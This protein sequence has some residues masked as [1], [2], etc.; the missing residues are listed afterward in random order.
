MSKKPRSAEDE[1]EMF[2]DGS[3]REIRALLREL[4]KS[5]ASGDNSHGSVLA[6][7]QDRTQ[8]MLAL[9]N[10]M[11]RRRVMLITDYAKDGIQASE[12]NKILAMQLS[13]VLPITIFKEAVTALADKI[14]V[15][16]YTAEAIRNVYRT[17]GF[18]IM[19]SAELVVTKKIHELLTEALGTG[20]PRDEVIEEVVSENENWTRAY[21]ENIYRTNIGHAYSEGQ[22]AQGRTPVAMAVLPA[23]EFHAVGD[24]DTRPNHLAAQGLLAAKTDPIWISLFPPLGFQCRCSTREVDVY[25][26]EQKDRLTL[27][28]S[29][30]PYYPASIHNAYRDTGFVSTYSL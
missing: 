2:L 17:K 28:G 8:D 5:Y 26:L 18:A 7:I 13:D 21:A 23:W 9:S 19:K 16:A 15:L 1:R 30:R 3:S 4:A 27:S 6:K 11:A 25:D 20:K 14:P 10:V 22:Q 24:S 12:R 29:V